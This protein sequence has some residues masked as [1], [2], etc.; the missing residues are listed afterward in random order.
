M[1][2]IIDIHISYKEKENIINALRGVS[3]DINEGDYTALIGPAGSGKSTL[4]GAIAGVISPDKGDIFLNKYR[5]NKL[6]RRKC[7][8]VRAQFYGIIFQFSELINRFTIEENLYFA[9]YAAHK[10]K[11]IE[12][13]KNRLTYLINMLKIDNILS[14]YPTKLSGGQMQKAAI[15]RALIKDSSIIL[16]DEPSG[17]L[18][19][20][21]I[22]LLKALFLEENSRGKTIFLVTHDMQLAFDAKTI[23]EFKDGKIHG[24]VK[25]D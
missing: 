10:R 13:Y 15:A 20:E 6:S 8:F 19:P 23:Y 18:D 12:E 22:E 24:I 17:D 1:I 25:H 9:W 14:V 7:A 21:N 4:L 16:A 3:L 11:N 5:L 2:R